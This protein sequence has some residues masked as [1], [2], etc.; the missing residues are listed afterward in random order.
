MASMCERSSQRSCREIALRAEGRASD[1]MRMRPVE[2][3]LTSVM[4]I[5]GVDFEEYRRM[6][7]GRLERWK[8][9]RILIVDVG[10]R[11]CNGRC[12]AEVRVSDILCG[13]CYFFDFSQQENFNLRS[14]AQFQKKI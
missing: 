9:G 10:R 8:N 11:T 1:N 14:Q 3:A 13:C 2:G 12:G 7:R 6:S 5:R 4:F